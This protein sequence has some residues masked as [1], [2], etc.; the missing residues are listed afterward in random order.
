[1][2]LPGSTC[3]YLKKIWAITY[4]LLSW[5]NTI[6]KKLSPLFAYLFFKYKTS[7]LSNQGYWFAIFLSANHIILSADQRIK[8]STTWNYDNVIPLHVS[9]SILPLW[10]LP[11]V[12][13]LQGR[14]FCLPTWINKGGMNHQ[15]KYTYLLFDTKTHT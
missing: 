9:Q 14:P 15:N 6:S 2:L 5:D 10:W 1:M 3:E 13:E 12:Q 7:F 8:D 4:T 11:R